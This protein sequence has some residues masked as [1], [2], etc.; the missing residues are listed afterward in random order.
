MEPGS[1]THR[2]R[3]PGQRHIWPLCL[4]PGDRA[5]I[6]AVGDDNATGSAYVFVFDGTTWS[7]E[8]KLIASDRFIFDGFGASVALSRDR[9]IVGAPFSSV[10]D[11]SDNGSAYTFF[12]DGTTWSEEAKL[13][14][15][16][17][18]T[19]DL[20]GSAVSLS[21]NRALI[22]AVGDSDRGENTGAAYILAFDGV[23]WSEQARLTASAG[24]AQD[25]F[26]NSVSLAGNRAL[27]GA[28]GGPFILVPG[29]AYLYSF[30]GATWNEQFKLTGSDSLAGDFFGGSVSLSGR[31]ALVGSVEFFNGGAGAAYVFGR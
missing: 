18:A 2:G 25:A 26:G 5:L 17:A 16:D 1:Q 14:A 6:G 13:N 9:A 23:S 27:I 22:A 28:P 3:R 21:G 8:A 4:N 19:N 12:F 29:A 7:Q 24:I 31:R 15:T 20:F 11:D 10:G 30:D